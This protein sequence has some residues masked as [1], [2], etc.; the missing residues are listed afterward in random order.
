MMP[1]IRFSASILFIIC[2]PALAES[3]VKISG[4]GTLGVV[5]TDSD[6]FGYRSGFSSSGGVFAGQVDFVESSNIGAQFDI[7][8]RPD[9]DAVVQVIYRNQDE[10]TLD[11]VLNMAFVRYS[12]NPTW[13]FRGGRI[14]L[15]LFLLTEY[16]DINF[17]H[18]WAHVPA[19]IYGV[20]PY[21][22]ID[23]LDASYTR[24]IGIGTFSSKLFYGESEAGVTGLGSP[25]V[26]SVKFGEVVGMALD[27]KT[28]G[29]D[30]SLNHSLVTFD[31]Q[32]VTPLVNGIKQLNA[33]VPGFNYIWPDAANL[34][35][36]MELD[37]TKATYTS[38]GGQYYMDR[39]TFMAELARI[40]A[41]SLSVPNVVGGYLSGIYH[42]GEHNFFATFA[43]SRTEQ[44]DGAE[45]NLALL[46]QI[47]GGLEI[48]HSTQMS[49]NFYSVNQQTLSLGWRWDLT[50]KLSFKLQWDHSRINSGGSTLW[51]PVEMFGNLDKP[52][53]RV[54]AI[55]SNLSFA[56]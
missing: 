32:L 23:G 30:I 56:F 1:M 39:M 3:T 13:S 46:Q 45:V 48:Y 43:F 8:M 16:R 5:V 11:S 6:E 12:P 38:V 28:M 20:V 50:E 54:N 36:G 42:A 34:A 29:W 37:N 52:T 24:R 2:C 51:Q 44:F 31:S 19:E 35:N 27:Y 7:I 17:A 14:A 18:P 4:F 55:F 53:G 47:P 49:L 40:R 33:Q 26:V 25:D 9:F 41:D 15:D 10:V 22:N 21:R